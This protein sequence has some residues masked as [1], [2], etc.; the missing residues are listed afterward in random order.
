MLRRLWSIDAFPGGK[1][2][3]TDN[4]SMRGGV[5]E[6]GAADAHAAARAAAIRSAFAFGSATSREP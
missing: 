5:R 6:P 1:S 3:G 2:S 4:D